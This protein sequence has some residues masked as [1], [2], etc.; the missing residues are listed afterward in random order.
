ML[1]GTD[2]RFTVPADIDLAEYSLVDISEEPDD[3]DPQ[4]SGDSIV[5]G[6]L[7]EG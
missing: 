5:R 4:H 1:D 3:G 7:R 6:P 2:G